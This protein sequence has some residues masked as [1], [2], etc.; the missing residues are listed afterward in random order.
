MDYVFYV[1]NVMGI[2]AILSVSLELVTGQTG[3]VSVAQAAFYGI[4][5]YASALL[6]THFNL[7][8][9]MEVIAGA[10][11]AAAVS[12]AVS[13]PSLRL[14]DDY[15]VIATFALQMIFFSVL[16][17]WT[18][19][20]RGPLGISGIPRLTIFE[21]TAASFGG[22]LIVTICFVILAYFVVARISLSPFGRVLHAIR[23]DEAFAEALGKDTLKFKVTAF[24]VSA[25]L[26]AMAGSLYAHLI[27]F[28]DPTSFTVLESILVLS[29]V[30]IGG[31]GSL[32][33]SF[34]GAVILVIL[35]EVLRIIGVPTVDA[36]ILR[37]VIYGALLVIMMMVRPFGLVGRFSLGR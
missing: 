28:I 33:G 19:V 12:L 18:E 16:N 6:A 24:A 26:A 35:P 23:E 36:A 14:R 13:V 29:M 15:F 8:F 7:P 5:A 1:L 22:F 34:I 32:W 10:S 17:N 11:L 20:T 2:F 30:I 4:G 31:A 27:T 25:A 21:W 9:A 37:Q 3:L